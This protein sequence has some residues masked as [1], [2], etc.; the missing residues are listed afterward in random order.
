MHSVDVD[1]ETSTYNA[2]R[3][4]VPYLAYADTHPMTALPTIQAGAGGR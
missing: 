4:A 2:P 3:R 1:V